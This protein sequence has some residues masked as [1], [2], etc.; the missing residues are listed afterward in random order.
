MHYKFEQLNICDFLDNS[1]PLYFLSDSNRFT[2]TFL[3]DVEKPEYKYIIEN[4]MSHLM[5]FWDVYLKW[6]TTLQILDKFNLTRLDIR[7][8]DKKDISIAY[9]I[10]PLQVFDLVEYILFKGLGPREVFI[11]YLIFKIVEDFRYS[12]E[13]IKNFLVS[14]INANDKL[15]YERTSEIFIIKGKQSPRRIKEATYLYPLIN[16]N[17]ISHI[18]VRR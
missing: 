8:K 3:T 15:T 13:D 6:G 14:E 9:F 7:S 2:D 11:P 1:K 4:S 16:D 12:V 5:R 17:F 10:K 18:I